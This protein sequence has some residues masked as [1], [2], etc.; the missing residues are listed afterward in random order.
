MRQDN[1]LLRQLLPEI[2]KCEQ[3]ARRASALGS[4]V[5]H[6]YLCDISRAR[7]LIACFLF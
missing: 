3:S 6:D 5:R 2:V 7:A 1:S 4:Q